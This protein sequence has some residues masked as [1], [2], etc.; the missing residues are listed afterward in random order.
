MTRL[1]ELSPVCLLAA[2]STMMGLAQHNQPDAELML[3]EVGQ[4]A[5]PVWD[6]AFV[7]HAGYWSHYEHGESRSAWP[8]PVTNDANAWARFAEHRGV[9]LDGAPRAGDVFLQWSRK[10]KRFV[11]VGI[12]AAYRNVTG[13]LPNGASYMECDTIEGN[14]DVKGHFPRAGIHRHTR[15]L[16]T[17]KGDRVIRWADLDEPAEPS[18]RATPAEVCRGLMLRAGVAGVARPAAAARAA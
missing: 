6:T 1:V 8:L 5:G 11:H 16:V 14:V 13:V 2:A 12:V 9:L 4:P 18:V 15:K 3:R 17:E 10:W 7:H